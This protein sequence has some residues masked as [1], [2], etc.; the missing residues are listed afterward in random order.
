[1]YHNENFAAEDKCKQVSIPVDRLSQL[2]VG[3]SNDNHIVVNPW[4]GQLMVF[5]S[6]YNK[7]LGYIDIASECYVP[8]I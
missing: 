3:L 6:A 7:Q 8:L 2:L 1:M 4:T 5:N